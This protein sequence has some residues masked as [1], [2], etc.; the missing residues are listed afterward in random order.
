[1]NDSIIVDYDPAWPPLFRK[2]ANRAL[3][4]VGDVAVGAE[5]VGSTAVPGLA[6]KPIIDLD[7]VLRSTADIPIAIARLAPLGYVHEG[8]L[9]I[10][11]REAFR[12]PPSE[13]RHHLYALP[14]DC[15]E[16][17][18]HLAFREYLCTHPD[19]ASAYGDL[20]RAAA[21]RYP[22]DRA[23]YMEAKEALIRAILA[24]ALTTVQSGGPTGRR[25][26]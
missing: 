18:R 23:A 26:R 24:R 5:H 22:G 15:P 2:L 17:R 7:L 19:A 1:M 16:L 12:W 21:Q 8:D 3:T 10:P 9:G 6:A 20:K 13:P 11:G 14:A 25:T 4:A